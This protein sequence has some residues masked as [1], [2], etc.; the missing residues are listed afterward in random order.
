M[1]SLFKFRPERTNYPS[2]NPIPAS[3]P[4][5]R[6]EGSTDRRTRDQRHTRVPEHPWVSWEQEGDVTH[7][8]GEF[9][10]LTGYRG[11]QRIIR[12]SLSKLAN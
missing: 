5:K 4:F 8:G 2:R 10:Q 1:I 7:E 3:F 6:Q 9:Q 12:V 11:N